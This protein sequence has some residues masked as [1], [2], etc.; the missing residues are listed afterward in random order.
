MFFVSLF[1]L[2]VCL[3]MSNIAQKVV[4]GLQRNFMK[5]SEMVKGRTDYILVVI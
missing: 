4:K 2:S 5:G 1:C 3:L